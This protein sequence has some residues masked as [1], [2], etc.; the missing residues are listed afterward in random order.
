MSEEE[1][2]DGNGEGNLPG[3][4]FIKESCPDHNLCRKDRTGKEP[5][6]FA[7]F[8]IL[9]DI[10]TFGKGSANGPEFAAELQMPL[11]V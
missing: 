2:S 8:L 11:C 6:L 5:L 9:P 3:H 7:A 1:G 4:V 10:H